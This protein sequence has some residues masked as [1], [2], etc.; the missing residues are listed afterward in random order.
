[1]DLLVGCPVAQRGWIMPSWLYYV[2]K[3]CQAASVVPEYIFAC[4]PRDSVGNYLLE[5]NRYQKRKTHFVWTQEDERPDV[6]EWN[7]AR[8]HHMAE[9]RNQLLKRVRVIDPTFFL[10]LDSD[11]LLHP[12]ALGMMIELTS[13]FDAVGGKCYMTAKGTEFPSNGLLT[14]DGFRRIDCEEIMMADIIMAIKLMSPSAYHVD[15]KF[16]KL[17]EDI[18]WS[19]NC[20]MNRLKLGWDGRVGSKHAMSPESL[21]EQDPR[22]GY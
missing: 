17:G 7:D 20:R 15:Y 21:L 13:R 3:A 10:S 18:G 4:D 22:V 8:F 2:E 19:E 12:D 6:R 5:L 11:I 9:I 16:H 14:V 1:M